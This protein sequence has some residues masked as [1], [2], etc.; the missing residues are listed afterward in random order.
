MLTLLLLACSNCPP[1]AHCVDGGGYNVDLPEGQ[2]PF[3]TLIWFHGHNGDADHLR[4]KPSELAS[5]VEAGWMVLVPQGQGD[6]WS[7][8][9]LRDG[10][11]T[12]DYAEAVLADAEERY[13]SSR[14]MASGYSIGA[15]VA[16]ELACQRDSVEAVAGFHGTFWDPM[17]SECSGGPKAMRHE[18]GRADDT[19][20]MEGRSFLGMSQGDVLEGVEVWRGLNG[21]GE[22]EESWEE[23][24]STCS[25]WACEEEPVT[26][27]EHEGVHRMES[28]F[29]QR[30][31]DWAAGL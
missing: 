11:Q 23:G 12:L 24:G 22:L 26:Y 10:G 16:Y 6:S 20:P 21:C 2:G 25:R 19:W 27:C 13:G 18:H 29:A 15:S 9:E 17:P 4:D 3:P 31:V 28:G 5:L 30:F 14:V 7:I 1:G 8:H